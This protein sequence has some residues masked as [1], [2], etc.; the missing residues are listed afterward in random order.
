MQMGLMG[1]LQLGMQKKMSNQQGNAMAT[2]MKMKLNNKNGKIQGMP[3]T[4]DRTEHNRQIANLKSAMNS[5]PTDGADDG[6]DSH[7]KEKI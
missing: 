7:F 1:K 3:R 2:I 4:N 5:K 6:I